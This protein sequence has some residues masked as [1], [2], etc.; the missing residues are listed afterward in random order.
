MTNA[1]G[2]LGCNRLPDCASVYSTNLSVYV[3]IL[4]PLARL[5]FIVYA[6]VK[7]RACCSPV[8]LCL[9]LWGCAT[10]REMLGSE[11]VQEGDPNGENEGPL[12]RDD[13]T[14][15]EY[16]AALDSRSSSGNGFR[17]LNSSGMIF[18]YV[19]CSLKL[20]C[21]HL[22]CCQLAVPNHSVKQQCQTAVSPCNLKLQCLDDM[23]FRAVIYE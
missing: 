3:Y 7:K 8:G 12:H 21:L 9:R 13:S 16:M 4:I 11:G 1:K 19:V 14:F 5:S 23:L 10:G 22:R 2:L 15:G 17:R 20:Q 18:H 6:H